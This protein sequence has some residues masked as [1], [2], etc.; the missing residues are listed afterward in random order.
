[1][2]GHPSMYTSVLKMIHIPWV[3]KHSGEGAREFNPKVVR[4]LPSDLL[5]VVIVY[6]Q[7]VVK[8]CQMLAVVPHSTQSHHQLQPGHRS[9]EL[10][11]CSRPPKKPVSFNTPMPLTWRTTVF[12]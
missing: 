4:N 10:Q 11:R 9:Y 12:G 3:A 6:L 2:C 1:M 8:W 5:D 7:E